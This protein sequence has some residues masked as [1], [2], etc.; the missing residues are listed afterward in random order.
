M[1]KTMRA[2]SFVFT[3]GLLCSAGADRWMPVA[4]AFDG[5]S[6]PYHGSPSPIPGTIQA[7]DFDSGGEGVAY[8]DTTPGNLGGAYRPAE[9]VDIADV[10]GGTVIGWLDQ[11]EWLNYTVAVATAG[12]YTVTFRVACQGQGGT[13]HLAMNGSDVTGPITVPDTGGWD[14]WTTVSRSINLVTG[15]QVATLVVDTPGDVAVG[16]VDWMQFAGG[17]GTTF[18]MMTW[19]IDFGYS[20]DNGYYAFADQV[21]YMARS[22]ADVIVLQEVS[23]YDV[24]QPT[25][26]RTSLEQATGQPW[27]SVWAPGAGCLTGGCIGEEILS[28]FPIADSQAIL[29]GPSSAGQA[30]ISINGVPVRIFTSHLEYTDTSLR[31]S[32]LLGLMDFAQQFAPDGAPRLV[33]GD[34]NSWWGEWWIQQMQNQYSDTKLDVTNTPEGDYTTGDV[35]FDYIFRSYDQ[36]SRLT[37]LSCWVGWDADAFSDHRPVLAD[38]LVQ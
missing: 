17:G 36:A 2:L 31:T 16:N 18:R 27:Y 5:A 32:Q 29:L 20:G 6:T 21:A 8:H 11:S 35:R 10:S 34:F 14:S 26:F 1:K 28:R 23:V 3:S 15:T 22:G 4:Y 37:P 25:L 30:L 19:N 38:F 7:E 24:D 33:G 13:F 12:Q 9:D